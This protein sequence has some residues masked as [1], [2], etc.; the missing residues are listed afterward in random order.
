[1]VVNA[2]ELGLYDEPP[3]GP[4]AID[5]PTLAVLPSLPIRQHKAKWMQVWKGDIWTDE[6]IC[7]TCGVKKKFM[8]AGEEGY[9]PHSLQE[10]SS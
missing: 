8:P 5:L 1:M 3:I 9:D 7:S 4:P 10:P 2:E 6:M